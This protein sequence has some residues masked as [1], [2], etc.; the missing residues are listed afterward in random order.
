MERA[1]GR[2][3]IFFPL[4]RWIGRGREAFGLWTEKGKDEKLSIYSSGLDSNEKP[5]EAKRYRGEVIEAT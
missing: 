4:D 5:F 3:G 1:R 2:R